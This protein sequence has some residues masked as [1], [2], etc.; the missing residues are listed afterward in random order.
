MLASARRSACSPAPLVGSVA[1]NVR[2]AGREEMVS[3]MANA[4]RF[5]EGVTL[6][7]PIALRV[8]IGHR[9]DASQGARV[10]AFYSTATPFAYVFARARAKALSHVALPRLRA[11]LRRGRRLAGRRHRGGDALGGHSGGLVLSRMRRAQGGFRAGGI[12]GA[13]TLSNSLK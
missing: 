12:L 11:D 7:T 9:Y 4:E 1:A 10:R 13:C 8:P 6:E 5:E 2:T 3:F